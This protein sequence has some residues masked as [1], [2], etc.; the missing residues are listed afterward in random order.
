MSGSKAPQPSI[1]DVI[2]VEE[3]DYQYGTGPL[4]LRITAV[5]V[6]QR[7][8]DGLWLPVRGHEIHWNGDVDPSERHA[9]VRLSA[10]RIIP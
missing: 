10:V 5:G 9:L 2:R 6:A 1:G 4:L 3:P 7:E 8:P